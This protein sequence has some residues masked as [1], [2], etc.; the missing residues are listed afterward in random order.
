MIKKLRVASVLVTGVAMSWMLW[1]TLV[2][3]RPSYAMNT[4]PFIVFL[5]AMGI[6][7][8]VLACREALMDYDSDNNNDDNNN[9][10]IW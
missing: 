4:L 2:W 1:F 7:P 5:L 6:A 3:S 8:F 10:E 9:K